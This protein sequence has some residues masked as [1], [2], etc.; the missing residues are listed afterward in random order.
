MTDHTSFALAWAI[1]Q[2]CI[3]MAQTAM[4]CLSEAT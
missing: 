2:K 1:G 4:M 3:M